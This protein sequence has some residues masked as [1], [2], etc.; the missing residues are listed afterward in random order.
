[1]CIIDISHYRAKGL[2]L[3]SFSLNNLL[4]AH[5]ATPFLTLIFLLGS[6]ISRS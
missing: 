4:T 1:M 5:V 2:L 3:N 6:H